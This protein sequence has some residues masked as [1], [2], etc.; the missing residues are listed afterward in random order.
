M[1]K[2]NLVCWLFRVVVV[3][4]RL[5][6]ATWMVRVIFLFLPISNVVSVISA[7]VVQFG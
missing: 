6:V 2:H 4:A 7:I 5:I 3:V 1:T